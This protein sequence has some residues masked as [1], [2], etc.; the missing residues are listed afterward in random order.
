MS[1]QM[2]ANSSMTSSSG[3]ASPRSPP[4]RPGTATCGTAPRGWPGACAPPGSPPSR[5]G[6]PRAADRV[7]RMAQRRR[8]RADRRWSTATTTSSRWTP[9]GAVEAPP[10]EP[11]DRR[12]PA[13]RARR[14]RRQGP[15]ARSTL[16][17]SARPL[18][19]DRSHRPAGHLKLIVEGEEESGSPHFAALLRR[20][21]ADR[22]ACDVVVVTDTGMW[23][24]DVP[25]IVHRHARDGCRCSVD[26]HGPVRDLH[27]GSFGGA[28]RNPLHRAGGAARR[29]ARRR[30]ARV[31]LPRLLRRRAAS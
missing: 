16:S 20:R 18:G 26:L 12:R 27:S 1:R 17:A 24:R 5:C 11:A 30:R 19:R 23:S 31:T 14:L 10:F 15:G 2:H 3:C 4:T 6:R 7:R 22:L 28:C 9:L 13:A 8:R 25:T 21:A 29:P